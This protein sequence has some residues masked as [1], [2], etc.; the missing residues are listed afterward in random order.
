MIP[1]EA[2]CRT[3]LVLVA[4]ASLSALT[5]GCSSGASHPT[6]SAP[7]ASGQAAGTRVTVQEKEY[8]LTLSQTAFAAGTYTFVAT[9][10]GRVA[11]ALAIAG[12]GISTVVETGSIEPGDSVDLTVT[13]QPGGYQLW[14]PVDDHKALGMDTH[15]TVGAASPGTSTSAAHMVE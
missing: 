4:A 7:G 12:P 5:A 14:C 13:L 1:R 3:A 6:S 15:I 9:D 10:V 2:G 11:H 8:S